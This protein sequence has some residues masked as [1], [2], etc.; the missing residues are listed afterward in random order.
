MLNLS[1]NVPDVIQEN[2]SR[3]YKNLLEKVSLSLR[4][5][6]SASNRQQLKSKCTEK[7]NIAV[8]FQEIQKRFN[9]WNAAIN[10]D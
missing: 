7:W 5:V 3:C 9:T 8:S 1:N 2:K 6:H 10:Q 4:E